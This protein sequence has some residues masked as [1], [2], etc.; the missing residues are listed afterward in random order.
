MIEPHAAGA[1]T[2][3][4][5]PVAA[6]AAAAPDAPGVEALVDTF[7]AAHPGGHERLIPLLH[8]LQ[9]RLGHVPF[10]AQD[11]VADRLGL[12]PIQ[13]FSVLSFYH[14]FTLTPRGRYPL[15]VCMGTA[16]FVRHATR[17]I[18][19]IQDTLGIDVGDCTPDRLFSLEQVRC[20]GACG[21]APAVMVG[22]DVHGNLDTKAMRRLITQL[23]SQGRREAVAAAKETPRG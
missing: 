11:V 3:A 16:C 1:A 10:E 19:T 23:R 22:Q 2:L 7:I 9:E 12:T 21:L 20:L 15:K 6:A 4:T 13:V 8:L 18:E 5:P 14:F 17:L